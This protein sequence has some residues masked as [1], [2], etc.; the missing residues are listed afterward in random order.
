MDYR[1]VPATQNDSAR[2]WEILQQAILRRKQDG[3][4][5][6]QDGYPNPDVIR[7]DIERNAGYILTDGDAIAGYAAILVNDEP[8]YA[9][10]EGAWLTNGD[11]V[12]VH[13]VAIADSHVGRGLA[14]TLFLLVEQ[15]TAD[16]GINSIKVDTNFDNPA[17]MHILDGLDYKY[18]GEVFFRGSARRAYEKVL[19]VAPAK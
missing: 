19:P 3:S 15:L 10:I 18:C 13:R 16:R 1:L 12:V 7:Q 4:R 9:V 11:F 17:M 2:I 5:Q 14:K 6:W 8:A